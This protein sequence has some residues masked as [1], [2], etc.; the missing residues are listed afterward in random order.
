VGG[1]IYYSDHAEKSEMLKG[2]KV[3]AMFA[4]GALGAGVNISG[5]LEVIHVGVPY[6]MIS[7]VQESGRAGR[8][9]EKV[10]STIVLSIR[11]MRRCYETDPGLYAAHPCIVRTD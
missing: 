2:W 4:T 9:G 3:G 10:R 1:R 11:E 8:V 6:G 5:I 7:F